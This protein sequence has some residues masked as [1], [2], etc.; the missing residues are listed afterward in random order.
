MDFQLFDFLDKY[1][2]L[3]NLLQVIN[4]FAISQGY[5][6]IKRKTKVSKKRVLGKAL[7][8]CNWNKKYYSKNWV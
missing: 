5:T 1:I 7:L 6:M 3:D 8:I 2:S 4:S